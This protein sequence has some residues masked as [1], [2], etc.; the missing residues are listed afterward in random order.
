MKYLLDT[1]VWLWSLGPTENI[2][3]RGLEIL[4]RGGEDVYLSAASSWEIGIKAKLGKY[5]LPQALRPYVMSRLAAQA[6]RS[7]PITQDH[8][9]K[10]YDLALHHYD[11][12]DRL[13]IAQAILENMVI[14]TSDR[15]FK[16]YPVEIVWCAKE[17][18]KSHE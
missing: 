4:E 7:L 13:I 2:G 3:R 17:E 11:P 16:K 18:A 8:T 15:I 9:L 12:F 10:V 5:K 6:I 14:L 1:M